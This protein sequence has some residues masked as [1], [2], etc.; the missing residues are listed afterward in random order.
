MILGY[1]PLRRY[2]T[3]HP[4]LLMVHPAHHRPSSYNRFLLH[5]IRPTGKLLVFPQPA[6][7]KNSNWTWKNLRQTLLMLSFGGKPP[8]IVCQHFQSDSFAT[9]NSHSWLNFLIS[10]IFRRPK[11][12][13]WITG[14]GTPEHGNSGSGAGS[15][16]PEAA[17]KSGW[18]AYECRFP[19]RFWSGTSDVFPPRRISCW[20]GLD[21]R[22]GPPF[23][24]GLAAFGGLLERPPGGASPDERR[25]HHL[26]S[27][28][29]Q[30]RS[31][32]PS[33]RREIPPRYSAARWKL[34][35]LSRWRGIRLLYHRGLCRAEAG[36]Y[37]R[38]R[39][40]AGAHPQMDQDQRWYHPGRHPRALLSRL[41]W[42]GAMEF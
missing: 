31:R 15:G 19:D 36:R 33:A 18:G 29:G 12:Q 8:P 7:G 5:Y 9:Y 22:T 41:D 21:H 10:V 28:H 14:P 11:R 35:P 1:S 42:P 25:V 37:E 27:F 6:R 23:A 32:P 4:A 39:R 16:E 34:E 26:Q 20:I 3:E 30:R 24:L 38:R 13:V 2:V 40:A 17:D